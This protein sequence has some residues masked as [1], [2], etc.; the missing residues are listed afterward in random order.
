V[1]DTIALGPIDQIPVGE[2]RNFAVNNETI[3]VFR[4]RAG[5]IYATQARCPHRSGPL[6]DGLLG[7]TTIVCPL[8][9]RAFDL[10]SGDGPS[11][12]CLKLKTY[13]VSLNDARE[14]MLLL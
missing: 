5:E 9:D 7:A 1:A 3:A 6:A 2:G 12:E 8:H 4:T 14:V 10:K 13:P 11:P